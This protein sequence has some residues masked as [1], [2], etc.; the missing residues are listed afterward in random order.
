[1]VGCV[2]AFSG[3][4]H[5]SHW[6]S[7]SLHVLHSLNAPLD[8]IPPQITHLPMSVVNI[9][10]AHFGHSPATAFAVNRTTTASRKQLR[11]VLIRVLIA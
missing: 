11:E 9:I 8:V 6:P 3:A 10:C 2:V 5:A 4:R 7:F 1:V